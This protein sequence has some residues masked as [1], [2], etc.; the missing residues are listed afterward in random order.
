MGTASSVV[1]RDLSDDKV[2]GYVAVVNAMPSMTT[3][4]LFHVKGW[5]ADRY[6][7]K[8]GKTQTWNLTPGSKMGP[9]FNKRGT[10][11]V[12]VVEG[13]AVVNG[14]SV[15]Q[16]DVIRVDTGEIV[17]L[18]TTKGCV[19]ASHIHPYVRHLT[20]CVHKSFDYS[21]QSGPLVS[22][23]VIAK[24]IETYVAHCI[25]SC[26]NQTYKNIQIIVVDDNSEDDTFEKAR[27]MAKYDS[28]V[29][30][31]SQSLGVNGVRKFGIEKARGDYCMLIDGDDWLRE[32]AVEK[33]VAV[34]QE[35]SSECVAFGFDHYND[36]TGVIWDPIYPTGVHLKSP[37]FYYEKNNQTAWENS[38]Y[39]HTVWMYFF[40]LRLKEIALK[41]LTHIY[42]YEDLPFY[43][44]LLQHAA[45]P[46]LCNYVL[47][48]YRRERAGQ[49]TGNWVAVNAT[50][51]RVCLEIS[52][53]HAVS[54]M[55]HDDWFHRLILIYK[56][57]TIVDY[58]INLV[59][60]QKDREAEAAWRN[61]W[62]HLLRLFPR[63]LEDRIILH[64]VKMD[65][66][67][68]H[69]PESNQGVQP[70]RWL[71]ARSK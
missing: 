35:R 30:V 13:S 3:P 55:D 48:H 38:Q 34:A 4:L 6:V 68:A 40:S 45:N 57:K 70:R 53:K 61:L 1:I 18:I 58:E 36:K 11:F 46:S 17:S 31:Y 32:D 27:S 65:F 56:V 66:R 67:N 22:I 21:S 28:R 69:A 37:P 62:L 10:E 52:V 71:R 54:L 5:F 20:H 63:D 8:D 43:L 7:A 19:L 23:V 41:A 44:T 33:L 50:Q 15:S 39:H 26:F 59:A 16:G 9:W 64:V 14:V 49:F 29:E 24:E 12:Q 2:P 51:K 25:S 47:Y 60:L 42:L